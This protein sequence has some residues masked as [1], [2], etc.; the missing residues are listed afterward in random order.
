ML[1]HTTRF[2]NLHVASEDLFSFPA[3]LIGFEQ[4]QQWVL[5]ADAQNDAVGWLQSASHA[6]IAIAVVSP[7]RFV[8]DYRVHVAQS[9]LASLELGEHDRTFV[10]NAVARNANGL[11][12][13]LKAPILFNLD[14]RLGTQIMTTDDQP[15]QWD[16]QSP[17]LKLRRS[18]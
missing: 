9:N 6:D 1:L 7:R 3:G 10:L 17:I 16:L 18:A 13:N 4:L 14:N 11:A 5:L 8:P 15:L 12:L 2:G